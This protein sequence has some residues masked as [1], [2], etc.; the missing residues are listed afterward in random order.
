[1]LFLLQ[2][3]KN[4]IATFCK[5]CGISWI[6]VNSKTASGSSLFLF[7]FAS[8]SLSFLSN[9]SRLLHFFILLPRLCSTDDK[10]TDLL[11]LFLSLCVSCLV[12]VSL[13]FCSFFSISIFSIFFPHIM[14]LLFIF[15]VSLSIFAFSSCY[16]LYCLFCPPSQVCYCHSTLL[17]SFSFVF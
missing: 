7:L 13:S 6:G 3:S 15:L 8:G 12:S 1:M 17:V 16:P 9:S 4:L 2:H 11:I 10:P 14:N 5:L